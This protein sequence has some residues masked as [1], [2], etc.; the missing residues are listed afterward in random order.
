MPIE[1]QQ[2]ELERIVR[3]AEELVSCDNKKC[4]M[5]GDYWKCYL[6]N[7]KGCRVYLDFML[8]K[9]KASYILRHHHKA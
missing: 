8:Q 6:G 7:Q 2:D 5:R 9:T 1:N 3:K 4:E